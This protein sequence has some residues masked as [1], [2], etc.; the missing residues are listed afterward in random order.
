M[1]LCNAIIEEEF[2]K[3]KT[4][5]REKKKEGEKTESALQNKPVW[6]VFGSLVRAR[7]SKTSFS[8]STFFQ[9]LLSLS[10]SLTTHTH[11]TET[12]SSSYSK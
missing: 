9:P 1:I 10:L 5:G 4:E 2:L 7:A 8:S 12:S 11:T 3:K 6:L